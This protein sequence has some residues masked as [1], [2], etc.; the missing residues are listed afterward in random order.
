MQ[1]S[2]YLYKDGGQKAHEESAV[3]VLKAFL[4]QQ[5]ILQAHRI[6]GAIQIDCLH[7][8]CMNL[9]QFTDEI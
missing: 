4:Q 9:E 3:S 2:K 6:R 1:C 8:L 5:G 7:L